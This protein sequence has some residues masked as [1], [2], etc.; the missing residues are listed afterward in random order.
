MDEFKHLYPF[1]SNEYGKLF[2]FNTA[3]VI[4]TMCLFFLLITPF[5]YGE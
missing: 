1:C 2:S 3:R 4:S 5:C